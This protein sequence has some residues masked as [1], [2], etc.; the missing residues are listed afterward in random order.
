MDVYIG[1][2]IGLAILFADRDCLVVFPFCAAFPK[3]ISAPSTV[4]QSALSGCKENSKSKN[5]W[6]CQRILRKDKLSRLFYFRFFHCPIKMRTT[7]NQ[8]IYGKGSFGTFL[9]CNIFCENARCYKI[10]PKL[11]FHIF[12]TY[13]YHTVQRL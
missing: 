1:C 5:S 9:K 7:L 8:H 13:Y 6:K 10:C 12:T 4:M 2:D 11:D 3:I